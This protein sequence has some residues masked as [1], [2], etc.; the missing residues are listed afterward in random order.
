MTLLDLA[1]RLDAPG[2]QGEEECNPERE[3]T[4][5]QAP[6]GEANAVTDV[7][8]HAQHVVAVAAA[9]VVGEGAMGR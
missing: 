7:F 1:R 4:E 2:Q 6:I 5:R 3:K 8:L 9:A